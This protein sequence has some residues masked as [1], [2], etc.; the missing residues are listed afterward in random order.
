MDVAE[1]IGNV[2]PPQQFA[3]VSRADEGTPVYDFP[4]IG[5][6]RV[7]VS[8]L[9]APPGA[10]PPASAVPTRGQLLTFLQRNASWLPENLEVRCASP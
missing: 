5:K 7:P 4:R 6:A 3:T 8:A 9:G 2:S 10:P 1:F